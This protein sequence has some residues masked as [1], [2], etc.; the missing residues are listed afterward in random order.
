MN[1]IFFSKSLK[2]YQIVDFE[3]HSD[4]FG[5]ESQRA[6]SHQSR[7][8]NIILHHI[9]ADSRLPH[10]DPGILNAMRMFVPQFSDNANRV[11]SS[12][13]S[14]SVWNNLQSLSIGADHQRVN[15]LQS[16]CVFA[17]F[18]GDFDLRSTTTAHQT[19]RND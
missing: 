18:L 7:L 8:Q 15:S 1:S 11:Q 12:I 6:L 3:N 16:P 14:Q 19:P 4:T 17:E 13:F 9:L 10:A 2:I 5:R